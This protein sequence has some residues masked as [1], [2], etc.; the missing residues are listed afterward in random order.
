MTKRGA[1]RSCFMTSPSD[2]QLQALCSERTVNTATHVFT[3]SS[4][5]N[6]GGSNHDVT[7]HTAV[8]GSQVDVARAHACTAVQANGIKDSVVHPTDR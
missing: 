6:G 1:L 2:D 5:V 4:F 3:V 8:G 7:P